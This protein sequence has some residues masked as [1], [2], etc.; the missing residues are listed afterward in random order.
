MIPMTFIEAFIFAFVRAAG[1]TAG[2]IL[3]A[4]ASVFLVY[5]LWVFPWTRII[6]KAGYK[7]KTRRTLTLMMCIPLIAFPV[8]EMAGT[9]SEL[10]AFCGVI[11][12]VSFYLV[13]WV[14]ALFPW[15]QV[16]PSSDRP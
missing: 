10:A 11:A 6:T 12:V 15:R 9:N 14:L 1:Q 8:A 5:L 7:G 16:K 3:A 2:Y 13:I 4:L